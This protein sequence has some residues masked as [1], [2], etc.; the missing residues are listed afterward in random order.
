VSE[1]AAHESIRAA[2]AELFN[3]RGYNSVTIRAIAAAAGCSPAMVI[4]TMGSK[5][6]LFALVAHNGPTDSEFTMSGGDDVGYELVRR[7]L[8][9]RRRGERDPW[10][11]VPILVHEAPDPEAVRS[12]LGSRYLGNLA[13]IIGDTTPDRR[14]AAIVLCLILGVA[15]GI[16]TMGLLDEA[17]IDDV[18]RFY[19]RLVQAEIDLCEGPKE[20]PAP[21][22][23]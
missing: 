20:V 8:E 23:H 18:A 9:R 19:G 6:Q 1:S 22:L 7:V 11:I 17:N 14:H 16:H 5:E 4:K 12:E 2:A 10:A 13:R 3:Q 21:K 15:S